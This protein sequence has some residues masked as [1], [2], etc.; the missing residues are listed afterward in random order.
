MKN[1]V[2]PKAAVLALG[3]Y[4]LAGCSYLNADARDIAFDELPQTIQKYMNDQYAGREIVGVELEKKRFSS[5]YLYAVNVMDNGEEW[6]V[7]FAT[8]GKVLGVDRERD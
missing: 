5:H 7:E 1:R 2:F 6:E 4:S 8:N 3:V